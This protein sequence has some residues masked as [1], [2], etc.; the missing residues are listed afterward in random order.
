MVNDER[1]VKVGARGIFQDL[2]IE[3]GLS[4]NTHGYLLLSHGNVNNR[5]SKP[6]KYKTINNKFIII[7]SFRGE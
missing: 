1:S 5:L 6:R 3:S 4:K 2:E 7:Y